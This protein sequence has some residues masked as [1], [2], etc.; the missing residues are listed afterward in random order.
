MSKKMWC[1]IGAIIFC[2]L[3]GSF[4]FGRVFP[5]KD[6]VNNMVK[7]QEEMIKK[8]YQDSFTEMQN[9]INS[10]QSELQK[11][12]QRYKN[13]KDQIAKSKEETKAIKVPKNMEETKKRLHDLGY[14]TK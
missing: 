1:I 4:Q 8:Q 5:D 6:I 2:F 14:P 13:I 11:S 12:E 3:F 9:H 10:L 7:K